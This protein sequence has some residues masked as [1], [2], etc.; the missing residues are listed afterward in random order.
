[1][2]GSQF[3]P[4]VGQ[5]AG[6]PAVFLDKDGT[7]IF[8][9]P[10]NVDPNLMRLTPGALE[11]L[12]ALHQAGF[13]L[14][15]VSNQSGVA[16]GYFPEAALGPVEVRMQALLAEAGVSLA[17]VLWCPHHPDGTVCQYAVRCDCRKPAPGLLLRAA[18]EHG[19]DLKRS[20]MIGDI[21]HD[22][23][24]GRRAGCRTILLDVGNETEWDLSPER[25]PDT[26]AADLR[27]A[28]EVILRGDLTPSAPLSAPEKRAGQAVTSDISTIIG[29]F[30]SKR[31]LVVGEA[32]LDT[33]FVGTSTRL[34]QEA[35]VPVV[36]IRERHDAPGGAAN[37]AVNLAALGCTVELLSV[38]G[39]DDAGHRLRDLLRQRGVGL[40]LL[41]V[42][43]GRQTLAKQR[44]VNGDQ[45]VVRFDQGHADAVPPEVEL[46]L[47]ER[48][49]TAVIEADAVVVSDYAYGVVTDGLLRQLRRL[50]RRFGHC[51][52]VDA[53]DLR[54]YRPL[55]PTLVKPNLVEAVNLA[56]WSEG[57]PVAQP[58]SRAE[59]AATIADTVLDRTGAQIAAITLDADG[60]LVAERGQTPYRTT[61]MPA[62]QA[63]TAGA[64]DTYLATFTLALAAGA[65]TPQAAELAARAAGVVVQLD[66]T[67]T[68]TAAALRR[69]CADL[70][71][72]RRV[73]S[74]LST[75]RAATT[76]RPERVPGK[77]DD[78]KYASDGSGLEAR[79]AATLYPA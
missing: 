77:R 14:I 53:R 4:S 63:R 72:D 73:G 20:W 29:H 2:T 42:A 69:A 31:V 25:T 24:A 18:R 19:I 79:E 39:D 5:T 17:D 27:E 70:A 10:Y 52:A 43:A 23:E 49:A 38:V 11:A 36:A 45:I 65:Q 34:C 32:M 30:S 54:Q 44:V 46:R 74:I 50:H 7:L 40:D 16:R 55:G 51:L 58:L 64:G 22:I 8:D 28:A 9:T 71:L 78:L 67:A 76:H 59:I 6:R 15:V 37:T 61:S 33:Y 35:A 41:V 13:L 12:R 21:L 62:D 3:S 1:M 60:A 26:V 48:L 68:C 57:D 75:G 56:T 66:G 47:R